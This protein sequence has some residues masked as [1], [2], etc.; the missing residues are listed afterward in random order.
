[1][2]HFFILAILLTISINVGATIIDIESNKNEYLKSYTEDG[3]SIRPYS[4]NTIDPP[5]LSESNILIFDS[6]IEIRSIDNSLF[7]LVNLSWGTFEYDGG[8]LYKDSNGNTLSSSLTYLDTIIF[9]SFGQ[10]INLLTI[11]SLPIGGKFLEN[12]TIEYISKVSEPNILS[13]LS[14][15][16][17]GFLFTKKKV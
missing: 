6:T 17:I 16:L 7:N 10:S 8:A 2:K 13:L 1:M 4:F 15:G 12:F 5:I 14:L 3:I 9:G 11:Q